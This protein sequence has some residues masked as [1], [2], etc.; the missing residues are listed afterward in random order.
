MSLVGLTVWMSFA[1][2]RGAVGSFATDL[3]SL[4]GLSVFPSFALT[5]IIPAPVGLPC[6]LEL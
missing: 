3:L 6:G 5:A 4:G 2:N 1:E